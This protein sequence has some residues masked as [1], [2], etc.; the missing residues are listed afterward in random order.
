LIAC[1]PDRSKELEVVDRLEQ[2]GL[3]LAIVADDDEPF[4]RQVE[5]RMAEVSKV[6]HGNRLQPRARDRHCRRHAAATAP[7]I[8]KRR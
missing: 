8:I 6:T 7:A 2:V 3:A 1:T 5:V 4:R